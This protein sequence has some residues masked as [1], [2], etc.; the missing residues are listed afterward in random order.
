MRDKHGV[1]VVLGDRVRDVQGRE[2][3]MVN[4]SGT[5]AIKFEHKNEIR[6]AF[7]HNIIE[8]QIEKY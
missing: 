7:L 8:S 3:E 1:E 4:L 6:Y 5:I 2:G